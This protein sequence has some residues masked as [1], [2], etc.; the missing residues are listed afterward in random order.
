MKNILKY[1]PIVERLCNQASSSLPSPGLALATQKSLGMRSLHDRNDHRSSTNHGGRVSPVG[2]KTPALAPANQIP[3]YEI[4][5]QKCLSILARCSA[6]VGTASLPLPPVRVSAMC[7]PNPCVG[8]LIDYHMCWLA[9]SFVD[10]LDTQSRYS[11]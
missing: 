11:N 6:Q 5:K 8:P 7:T 10:K 3:G 9:V 4:V 1:Y 2:E